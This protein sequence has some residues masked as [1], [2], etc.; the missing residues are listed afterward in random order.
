MGGEKISECEFYSKEFT[1]LRRV[2][3]IENNAFIS[4]IQTV[5]LIITG[6]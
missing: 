3:N 1:Q 5:K 2:L 6:F 4:P